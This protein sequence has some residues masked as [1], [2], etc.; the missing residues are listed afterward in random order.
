MSAR[1]RWTVL[2]ALSIGVAALAG[3]RLGLGAGTFGWPQLDALMELRRLRVLTA[4]TIGLALA[5]AG[6]LLQTVMRNP[7]ASPWVLGMT[8]GAAL[9]VALATLLGYWATG[10]VRPGQPAAWAAV[11]G[12]IG[13]L[14][15]VLGIA[16]ARGGR[17]SDGGGLDPVS[18]VLVGVVVSVVLGSLVALVQ[19]LLPDMG[20][21]VQARWMLGSISDETP[22][23]LA[24]AVAATSLAAAAGAIAAAPMLDALTLS[25]AEAHG[26][27]VPVGRVRFVAVLAAGVLTGGTVALAGPIGFAG[28]LGPHLARLLVGGLHRWLVPAAGLV[29]MVLVLSA[30]VVVELVRT[31]SGRMPVGV[32]MAIVGGPV[33]LVLLMRGGATRMWTGQT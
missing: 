18:L 10:V 19:H 15:L 33:F 9:G 21:A 28:L 16:R 30:D 22:W 24:I 23:W 17:G 3:V 2:I 7:L 12:A 31:P 26:L 29:G 6:A 25:D 27:G 4:A 1:R 8:S 13:A 11:L 20:L 14:T 5:V 32:V